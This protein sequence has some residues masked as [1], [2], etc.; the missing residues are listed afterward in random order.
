MKKIYIWIICIIIL[1]IAIL[2]GKYYNYKV[3]KSE[4][5]EFNLQYEAYLEKE[6]YGTELATVINKA[7]DNNDRN[8]VQKEEQDKDDKKY[9]FY[10]PNDINSI[11]LDI[12]IT[13]NNTTYKME[14]IYQAD[15]INFVQ[16]YNYIKFKCTK[17]EY[18]SLGKVS[19][20]LFEQI[21]R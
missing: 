1:I 10:I 14:S 3:R 5:A 18:N 16:N 12:K 2:L 21:S 17:I 4:L 11:N 15:I 8:E 9:Y 20:L 7:I 6:I 19:Y 13:D